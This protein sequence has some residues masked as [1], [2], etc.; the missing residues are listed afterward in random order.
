MSAN[1]IFQLLDL[2]G[3][4][5]GTRD[6]A[7]NHVAQK[8]FRVEHQ[9]ADRA[10]HYDIERLQVTVVDGTGFGSSV[11]GNLA[12]AMTNGCRLRL[13]RR[14]TKY[15]GDEIV[16]DTS[17]SLVLV[18][19]YFEEALVKN[20]DFWK[21]GF[22]VDFKTVGSEDV[23]VATFDFRKLFG[24]PCRVSMAHR[25]VWQIGIDD[26]SLLTEMYAVAIGNKVAG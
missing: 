17:Q 9:D 24:Q 13:W 5:S 1:H 15:A 20:S 12:A 22:D 21:F 26:L 4:G 3:D 14:P 10:L 6:M 11:F 18:K 7:S 23:L 2:N 16:K 8:D 25:L 19:D